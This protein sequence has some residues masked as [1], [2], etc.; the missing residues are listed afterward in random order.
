MKVIQSKGRSPGRWIA[1]G[2]LILL[3]TA[4]T[5]SQVDAFNYPYA[6]GGSKGSGS[7]NGNYEP[8]ATTSYQTTML[9]RQ[10][11]PDPPG[12][13]PEPTTLLLLAGGLGM[14]AWKRFRARH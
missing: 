12:A 6:T 1:V 4:F 9:D 7:P 8:K 13:V 2:I 14:T 3:A 5:V 11:N 10:A